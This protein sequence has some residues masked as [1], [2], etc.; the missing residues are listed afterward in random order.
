MEVGHADLVSV[1]MVS[2]RL[3]GRGLVQG[4]QSPAVRPMRRLTLDDA[5]A[6]WILLGGLAFLWI[7]THS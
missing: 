2:R 1:S 6:L 3:G 5:L 4:R 7:I